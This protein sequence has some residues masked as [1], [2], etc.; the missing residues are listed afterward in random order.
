M[1]WR[2]SDRGVNTSGGTHD[3]VGRTGQGDVDVNVGVG[4]GRQR[5]HIHGWYQ[6]EGVVLILASI[7]RII[8]KNLLTRYK[9]K[10]FQHFTAVRLSESVGIGPWCICVSTVFLHLSSRQSAGKL[11]CD[12][13]RSRVRQVR[14]H[15]SGWNSELAS[16]EDACD[17]HFTPGSPSDVLHLSE[18][19]ATNV[20]AMDCCKFLVHKILSVAE[21]LRP[22]GRQLGALDSTPATSLPGQRQRQ[23]APGQPT[24]PPTN[25][26]PTNA[27][28]NQR[29]RQLT[30][31]STNAS[32]IQNNFTSGKKR[33]A[34]N[35][36]R[37]AVSTQHQHI[38]PTAPNACSEQ[39]RQPITR[40]AVSNV[41]DTQRHVVHSATG[42]AQRQ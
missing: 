13:W 12:P 36:A 39:L 2:A 17:V 7:S 11:E 42:R 5:L 37:N 9:H 15:P 30:S 8:T 6:H 41:S 10:E 35:A 22:L 1:A 20:E 4:V 38:T 19:P 26:G 34:E 33:S 24:P 25:A 23:P 28:A 29:H 16:E 32:N 21:V 31:P 27:S 14:S 3:G 18:L 40:T